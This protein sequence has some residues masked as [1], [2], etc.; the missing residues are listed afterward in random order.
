MMENI[1][2]N[3]ADGLI[4]NRLKKIKDN[5]KK[6]SLTRGGSNRVQIMAVTKNV[7]E[8]KINAAIRCGVNLIGENRVQ[9]L[10]KK[11]DSINLNY[12][13]IHFIGHLQKNKVKRVIDKVSVIESVDSVALAE[14]INNR[15]RLA[16]KIMDV[17]LEINIGRE[18]SKSGFFETDLKDA[19][20]EMSMFS[21]I[22]ILGLMSI[23]PR[24]GSDY[25]FKKLY[26]L[27]LDIGRIKYYN[28]DMRYLSMGMSDDY[29]SAVREGANIIRI[30]RALF[31]EEYNL[32]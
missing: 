17:F 24:G 25:Y 21:N 16:G 15:A 1:C 18:E 10:V 6:A 11:Y 14:E 30:G 22:R 3:D 8:N 5:V 23:P 2:G 13:N 4:E 12:K 7:S 31:D 19:C 32:C 27:F 29:E 9:E 28:V 20:K 26:K